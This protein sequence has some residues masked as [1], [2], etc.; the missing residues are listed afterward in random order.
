M[1]FSNNRN[2]GMTWVLDVLQRVTVSKWI[3][4]M[5][6]GMRGRLCL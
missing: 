1:G 6:E 3:P 5:L 4:S 2:V